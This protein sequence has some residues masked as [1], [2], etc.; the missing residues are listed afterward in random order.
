[1]L[2]MKKFVIFCILAW[3]PFLQGLLIRSSRRFVFATLFSFYY[4]DRVFTPLKN[5]LYMQH[6][7]K[8]NKHTDWDSN[9][10]VTLTF[11]SVGA[12]LRSTRLWRSLPQFSHS[13]KM[14]WTLCLKQQQKLI[15]LLP[16]QLKF[17]VSHEKDHS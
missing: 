11:T 9:I 16:G 5:R 3:F 1:M 10:S 2:T 15:K 13:L 7:L 4:H 8:K 14:T 12:K 6:E 17:F